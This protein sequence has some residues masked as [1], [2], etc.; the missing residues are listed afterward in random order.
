MMIHDFAIIGAGPVGL[1]IAKYLDVRF[2]VVLVE[3]GGENA[4][5]TGVDFVQLKG[6]NSKISPTSAMGV[7]GGMILW[8]GRLVPYQPRDFEDEKYN[9]E[10]LALR[11][12]YEQVS[13][14]FEIK[15]PR[16][17]ININNDLSIEEHY[18][19]NSTIFLS[20]LLKEVKTRSKI[21]QN[22]KVVKITENKNFTLELQNGR[23]LFARKVIV[24]CGS[25]ETHRLLYQSNLI[26]KNIKYGTHPKVTI[27]EATIPIEYL[28]MLKGRTG[29]EKGL[30]FRN[31]EKKYNIRL[32]SQFNLASIDY[33]LNRNMPTNQILRGIYENV[34]F[35]MFARKVFMF[36]N[37]R[38]L[39]TNKTH[40]IR[41]FF[42]QS[43]ADTI[44]FDTEKLTLVQ[45]PT[46]AKKLNEILGT[47]FETLKVNG[48]ENINI[49][50]VDVIAQNIQYAHSHFTGGMVAA[51]DDY[52]Q[53][54]SVDGLYI[55]TAS[56]LPFRV[57]ANP[58]YTLLALARRLADFLNN[59][60]NRKIEEN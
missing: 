1:Y 56:L 11:N 29:I 23:K 31:I 38:F 32:Y 53:L 16:S 2:N 55:C 20:S 42:D 50:P 39:R 3:S 51:C 34:Y 46:F 4:I 33:L 59:H 14:D 13:K 19:Y 17:E 57:Y 21:M 47:I 48:F 60:N 15:G 12:Y 45:D 30:V 8:G 6:K 26:S 24:A 27:G 44:L 10:Q 40:K 18:I 36:L 43:H 7:G 58:T 52:G 35:L 9:Y 28:Q 54:T 25:L 22:C 37:Q 41:I 49:H 5:A